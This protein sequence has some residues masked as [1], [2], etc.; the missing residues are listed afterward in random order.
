[1]IVPSAG[2]YSPSKFALEAMSEAMAYELAPHGVEVCVIQP[3]GY[4]T[5]VWV[6]RNKLAKQLKDRLSPE[7]T[8]AYP[9]LVSRMG[10]EDGGGRNADPLDVPKAIA[11]IAAMPPGTR[12]LRRA[13]H[14]GYR[15]QEAINKVSAET[16][17]AWLGNSPFG[18]W[19]KAVHD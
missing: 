3:G 7:E 2:H 4:P 9:E 16:Q 8:A 17:L 18:P 6:N 12:P 1:V 5:K 15:P 19:I 13:V 10:G 14:P 11:E